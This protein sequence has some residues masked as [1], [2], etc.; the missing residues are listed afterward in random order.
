MNRPQRRTRNLSL[1]HGTVA[2][3]LVFSACVHDHEVVAPGGDAA[4]AAQSPYEND[5]SDASVSYALDASRGLT[6]ASGVSL[7]DADRAISDASGQGRVKRPT[8]SGLDIPTDEGPVRGR[9]V[10]SSRVFLGIPYAR[11]PVGPMRWRA[12]EPAPRRMSVH[13]ASSYGKIC[14]QALPVL[15]LD[16]RS[17]E[18]C[19]TLNVWA[20]SPAP[21]RAAPVL[22]W[23]HGG[24]F[25]LGSGGDQY[26]GRKLAEATGAVVVTLNYRLGVLGF[27]TH[28]AL[29]AESADANNF[30]IRDQQ[31]ALRWVRAN[32]SAFGG[33]DSNVTVF[34]ESAGGNSICVHLVTPSSAGLFDKAIVQSGLCLKAGLSYAQSD[35]LGQ[36]LERD[37]GCAGAA[38]VLGCL[39]AISA[40][41]L[42]AE[43][44]IDGQYLGGI[45]YLNPA[46]NYF[47][48][49]VIDGELI[50][51]QLETLFARGAF[52]HVPLL[53]GANTDEGAL[54][55]IP[56]PLGGIPIASRQEFVELIEGRFPGHT[57]AIEALYAP[58][59]Y[60]SWNEALSQVTGDSMFLCPSRRVAAYI[61]RGGQPNYLYRFAGTLES[62]LVSIISGRSFHS[63]EVS[64]LLIN[65]N[66]LG[67]IP[68]AKLPLARK[69][70]AIWYQF[71]STGTPNGE[72]SLGPTWHPYDPSSRDE[73][74]LDEP[75]TIQELS[76]RDECALWAKVAGAPSTD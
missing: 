61:T 23:I 37:F 22:V 24:A 74:V 53:H 10:G 30:G 59:K 56:F 3:L 31:S 8:A 71:A 55:H 5:R 13:D 58:P 38:D 33:D 29:S 12:P 66:P 25:Q 40:D 60:E 35:A 32:I 50:P 49:P 16:S 6:D 63:A 27:L 43:T 70:R 51:D 45:V 26:D 36:Q 48:Q 73:F 34:G 9:V 76:K 20:P 75:V 64:Y 47:F 67:S 65:D 4:P 19:L 52:H 11:A 7:D 57:A 41:K 21:A 44:A 17:D 1:L 39:R 42:V 46:T 15:G 68:S 62:T 14:P 54:F 69:L 2:A 72:P 18:D 28:P